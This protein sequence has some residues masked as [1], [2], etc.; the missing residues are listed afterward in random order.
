MLAATRNRSKTARGPDW[1]QMFERLEA[2]ATAPLLKRFYARGTV[3]GETAIKDVPFVALDLETTGMSA[4]RHGIVSVGLVPFTL[5]RIRCA[6][7]RYWLLRP[8]RPLSDESIAIHR[9]THADL[10]RAPDL[11]EI[12]PDLLD[13]LAG[14]VAVVHY[15]GLERPFLRRA[16]RERLG[17]GLEFPVVDTMELEARVHRRWKNGSLARFFTGLV[18]RHPQSIRLAQSRARYNL[19]L[20]GAHHALTDALASAELLQAQIAWRFSPDTPLR[21]IWH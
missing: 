4:E 13:E 14:R 9:I 6:D 8:R 11:G 18:G 20:Y 16:V 1:P 2:A 3:S 7:S 15:R 17:E 12:L 10:R 19:P 5:A 21:E